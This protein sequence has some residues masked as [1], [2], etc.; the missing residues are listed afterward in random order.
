[1][2]FDHLSRLTNL[3][4]LK[5]HDHATKYGLAL[6]GGFST[7]HS[8]DTIYFLIDEP[9][10]TVFI[11]CTLYGYLASVNVNGLEDEIFLAVRN[12]RSFLSRINRIVHGDASALL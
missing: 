9:D 2:K 10:I 6:K 1:M 11:H 7:P 3:A 5:V 4:A 12:I 8:G